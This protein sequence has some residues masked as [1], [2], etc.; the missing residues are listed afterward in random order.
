[1]F[2]LWRCARK[3]SLAAASLT[4]DFR[5]CAQS[6]HSNRTAKTK[7]ITLQPSFFPE[8][9]T[10]G[11]RFFRTQSASWTR[12]Y[13]LFVGSTTYPLPGKNRLAT[14][15]SFVLDRHLLTT[16]LPGDYSWWL[17]LTNSACHSNPA[18]FQAGLGLTRHLLRSSI[19]C[20]ENTPRHGTCCL[21]SFR[22]IAQRQLAGVLIRKTA[23]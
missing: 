16:G 11:H 23:G 12:T 4:A 8:S 13:R 14:E 20:Q 7:S 22:M 21:C 18:I 1:M 6:L 19:D 3:A 17:H 15:N 9:H 5:G 10:T 2:F